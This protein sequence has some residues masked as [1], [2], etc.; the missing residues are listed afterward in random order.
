VAVVDADRTASVAGLSSSAAGVLDL[1]GNLWEWQNDGWARTPSAG[2]DVQSP[3]SRSRVNRG[4][5][6]F[7]VPQRARVAVR[8]LDD[9]G[10]RL[11]DLGFR[12]FRTSS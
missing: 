10:F 8:A 2:V 1:S 7:R 4:G 3:T 9:P 12:L 11:S 5:S 6:W